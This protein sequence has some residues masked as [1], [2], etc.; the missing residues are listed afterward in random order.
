MKRKYLLTIFILLTVITCFLTL[1]ACNREHVHIF[2]G[3]WTI[4]ETHHWHRC[5]GKRGDCDEK[6]S[7]NEHDFSKGNCICG[8]ENPDKHDVHEYAEEYLAK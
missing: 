2:T 4:D 5:I 8:K 7:Y 3:E 1:S 6:N